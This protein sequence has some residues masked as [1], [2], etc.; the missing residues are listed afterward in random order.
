M[1]LLTAPWIILNPPFQTA[2]FPLAAR[3]EIIMMRPDYGAKP[4]WPFICHFT[5]VPFSNV[6]LRRFA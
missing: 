6:S 2:S 5:D 4:L 3:L 1:T